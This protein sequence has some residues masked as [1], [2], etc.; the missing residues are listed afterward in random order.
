MSTEPEFLKILKENDP[1]YA[2][3]IKKNLAEERKD[4]ALPAKIKL[5]I[6]M[7]LDAAHGDTLG[8]KMLSKQARKK[9]ATDQELLE[10][11]KIVGNTCGIQGLAIAINGYKKE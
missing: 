3:R 5:L 2:E 11:I 6:A 4:S 10:T 1:E 7:A 8:V 9:G